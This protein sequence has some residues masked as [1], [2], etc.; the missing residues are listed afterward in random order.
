MVMESIYLQ[1]RILVERTS[2]LIWW[3]KQLLVTTGLSNVNVFK[4]ILL[5]INLQLIPFFLLQVK[6]FKDENFQT[7]VSQI[8]YGFQPQITGVQMQK[9]QLEIN[10]HQYQ[11]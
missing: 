7:P 6:Q 9:K 5:L 8:G 1:K 11:D 4:R 2:E 10:I 3:Q